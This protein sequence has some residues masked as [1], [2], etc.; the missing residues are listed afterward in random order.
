MFRLRPATLPDDY[1]HMAAILSAARAVRTTPAEVADTHNWWP[2]GS[3]SYRV[4]AEDEAGQVIG[5]AESYRFPN[6]AEG[7]FYAS[8]TVHPAARNRGSGSLLLGAIERFVASQGGNR[9]VGEVKDSDA[10]SLAFMEKRAYKVERHGYDS[11][12]DLSGL[13]EPPDFGA[14]AAV[15]ATGIRFFALADSDSPET[16]RALYELYGR[17]MVDIPG[18]EAKSFMAYQTW[19]QFVI[20]GLGARL[21]WIFIAADDDCLVGVTQAINSQDH[22]YTNHTLVDREY[23]GR[24]IAKALKLLAIQAAIRHGAPYMRTGNDSLNGPM[25]AVNRKLGYRPLAGDYTVVRHL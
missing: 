16:R 14:V 6:T 7:K 25:L 19:S 21:D 5:F 15:E 2:E 24:G 8:L 17:T 13:Q 3:V 18:Y 11:T 9:L 20:E 12:L 10:A 22:V 1:T 23:R 4:M